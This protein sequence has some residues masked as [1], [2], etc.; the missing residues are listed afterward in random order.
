MELEGLDLLLTAIRL[1]ILLYSFLQNCLSSLCLSDVGPRLG[2]A[3]CAE[4][5]YGAKARVRRHFNKSP[6]RR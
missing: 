1:K 3:W 4:A 6:L 2:L 5:Q